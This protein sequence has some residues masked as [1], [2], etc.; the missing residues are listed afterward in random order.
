[1]RKIALLIYIIDCIVLVFAVYNGF[2]ILTLYA[3][4][5][6]IGKLEEATGYTHTIDVIVDEETGQRE[7]TLIKL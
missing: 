6:A 2:L 4:Y 7:V 3:L 5:F 1:M